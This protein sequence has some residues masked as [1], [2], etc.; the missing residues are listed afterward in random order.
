MMKILPSLLVLALAIAAVFLAAWTALLLVADA[1][2]AEVPRLA[3]DALLAF[4]PVALIYGYVH[5]RRRRRRG[6][7]AAAGPP[8]G[9]RAR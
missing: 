4:P 6:A 5:I 3:V 8:A 7:A 2:D 1:L 9:Q